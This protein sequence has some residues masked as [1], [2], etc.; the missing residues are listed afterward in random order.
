MIKTITI[1]LSLLCS[2]IVVG[3]ERYVSGIPVPLR[4]EPDTSSRQILQML[5]AGERVSLNNK[6]KNGFTLVTTA[7]GTQG[8][9]PGR[10]LT[11]RPSISSTA[12]TLPTKNSQQQ[13][14]MELENSRLKK[15]I[16]SIQQ[17]KNILESEIRKLKESSQRANQKVDTIRDASENALEMENQNHLLRDQV[18][19]QKQKL[20]ALQQENEALQDRKDRDWFMVGALVAFLALLTGFF[21]SRVRNSNI[22]RG[23]L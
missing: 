14:Q 20:E 4:A 23:S 12:K 2:Q 11:K 19:V 21:L 22:R 10:Y 5:S 1:I 13:M 17:E 7:S 9:I 3:A 8:W 16:T 6:S 15:R 18:R